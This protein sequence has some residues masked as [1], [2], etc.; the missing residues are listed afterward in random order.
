MKFGKLPTADVA[1]SPCK[2]TKG[3][4][5]CGQSLKYGSQFFHYRTP[6]FIPKDKPAMLMY[7]GNYCS[8]QHGDKEYLIVAFNGKNFTVLEH[9][10][11]GKAKE[12][13]KRFVGL[14]NEEA[15]AL[16]QGEWDERQRQYDEHPKCKCGGL[17]IVFH[18]EQRA[19]E[20]SS[21]FDKRTKKKKRG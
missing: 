4:T 14:T 11:P 17:L 20:C 10:Y 3:S 21:C 9:H 12:A 15:I 8:R 5:G 16:V 1:G 19:D 7:E 2:P 6:C 13:M 18:E